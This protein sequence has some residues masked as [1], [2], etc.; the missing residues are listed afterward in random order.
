MKI[1]KRLLIISLVLFPFG[2]KAAYTNT[3]IQT[4]MAYASTTQLIKTTYDFKYCYRAGCSSTV[5]GTWNLANMSSSYYRC[6]NGNSDPYTSLKDDGCAKYSGKC[7]P[8]SAAYCTRIRHIDCTK[9]S[10]GQPYNP[11]T[12]TPTAPTPTKSNPGPTP[13]APTPTVTAESTKKPTSKRTGWSR[14][15]IPVTTKEATTE[16]TRPV[17]TT[18]TTAPPLSNNLNINKITINDTD[19]K[20]RN[21]YDEYTIKLP[22]GVS[23]LNIVVD[24]EDDKTVTYIEGAYNMPD[25]DTQVLIEA[26]AEDGSS[27]DIVINVKRYSGESNDCNIANIVVNGYDFIFDK[28]NYQ[29]NLRIKRKTK[30]LDLEIIPSDPLHANVEVLGNSNLKNNSNVAINIKA[31]NGSLCTYNITVKKSSGAWL[32]VLITLLVLAGLITAGYFGYK[33]IKRSKDQYQYE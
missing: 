29:Y 8:S 24:T 20:Y 12:P 22:Y 15:T 18:D 13:T 6:S 4:C 17:L 25:E 33:Y 11:P 9:Q 23:D 19:I 28:N 26:V 7:T 16:S 10:N 31:E 21:G 27:K 5:N 32:P 2:V 1:A 30:S 14:V 3:D